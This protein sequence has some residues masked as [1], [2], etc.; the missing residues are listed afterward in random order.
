MTNM[1]VFTSAEPPIDINSVKGSIVSDNLAT[2]IRVSI[3]KSCL[4]SC[5]AE[6]INA[7]KP[8]PTSTFAGK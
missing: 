6:A 8:F 4:L 7:G 3:S 1:L 5:A 2:R